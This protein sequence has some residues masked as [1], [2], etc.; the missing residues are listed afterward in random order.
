MQAARGNLKPPGTNLLSPT[1]AARSVVGSTLVHIIPRIRGTIK[2]F[3]QTRS[4]HPLTV[5][6]NATGLRERKTSQESRQFLLSGEET[7]YNVHRRAP[8]TRHGGPVFGFDD[9]RVGGG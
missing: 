3:C 5:N 4:Y 8:A 6:G 9:T 1:I 2:S 7:W